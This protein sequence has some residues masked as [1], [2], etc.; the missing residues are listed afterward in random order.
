M[1]D[2]TTVQ[3]PRFLR[4]R[5]SVNEANDGKLQ[6]ILEMPG[7]NKDNLE[8]RIENNELRITGRREPGQEGK[9]ILR[10]RTHGDFFQTYTLDET[11]DSSKVDAVLEK[12][13]LVLTLD[14]KEHVKPR[15]ITVKGE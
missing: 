7:V 12:G 1:P 4:P 11:V 8:V 9:Y 6:V 2:K 13:I 3:K 15:T 10:E 5:A 14:L